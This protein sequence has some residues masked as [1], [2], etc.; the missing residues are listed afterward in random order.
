MGT[1][2]S[3][4]PLSKERNQEAATMARPDALLRLHKTLQGRL[5]DLR[6]KLADD[7]DG[8]R[9]QNDA[10]S[11]GD[12]ADAAFE[13][14]SD[15]MASQL[16]ELDSREI[17]QIERALVRLRQGTYGLCESC[18]EKIPVGRLNALPYSTLC[19]GCQREQ[20][21]F[22]DWAERRGAANWENVFD[23]GRYDDHKEVDLSKLEI[24]LTSR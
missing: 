13:S 1:R 14:G 15:E 5:T 8:L 12:V 19:I 21:R 7:L 18:G 6:K 23:A 9:N 11:N 24:D 4:Q 3:N 2:H 17:T 20:E 10:T 22:P 16:A